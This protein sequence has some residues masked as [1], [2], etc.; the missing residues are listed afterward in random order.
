MKCPMRG[1]NRDITRRPPSRASERA[2]RQLLRF[3]PGR[4]AGA[5]EGAGQGPG[6]IGLLLEAV[7]GLNEQRERE[8]RSRCSIGFGQSWSPAVADII[9][10]RRAWTVAMIS[11]VSVPCR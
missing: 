8:R 4:V 11:S 2:G 5:S 7:A 6:E 1:D 3:C 10:A 9:G